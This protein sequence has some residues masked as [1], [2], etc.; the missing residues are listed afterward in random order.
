MGDVRSKT[1]SQGQILEKPC[2]C[3]R[4][5]IFG[6]ILMKLGQ[7]FCLDKIL[8]IFEN[9]HVGS[10]NRS[11]GQIIEDP[12]LVTKGLCFKS[13]LLTYYHTMPHFDAQNI[14]ICGKLCEKRR[15]CL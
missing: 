1:R 3:S 4:D 7:T 2:V 12:M 14:D 9:G 6:L 8:Y 11:L 10:K 13:L 5:Q 15:T